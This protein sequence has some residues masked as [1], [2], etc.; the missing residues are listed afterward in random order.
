[1]L[2]SIRQDG[3][4]D[5]YLSVDWKDIAR[6]KQDKVYQACMVRLSSDRQDSLLIVGKVKTRGHMRL[7]ICSFPPLKLKFDKSELAKCGLSPL[8]EMDIVQQCH[9]G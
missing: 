5:L 2:N 4:L 1:M 9:E 6:N 8:N 7:E 3:A